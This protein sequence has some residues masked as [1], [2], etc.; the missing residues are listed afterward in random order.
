MESRGHGEDDRESSKT[1]R[2]LCGSLQNALLRFQ[3][4]SSRSQVCISCDAAVPADK[5]FAKLLYDELAFFEKP[6]TLSKFSNPPPFPHSRARPRASEK[7]L[8]KSFF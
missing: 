3:I 2:N 4:L 7:R 1:R 5:A 6:R 8:T